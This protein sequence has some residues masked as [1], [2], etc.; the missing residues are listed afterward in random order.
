MAWWDEAKARYRP[1]GP[2]GQVSPTDE[3]I[4]A[5]LDDP[6]VSDET[7]RELI[8]AW[9]YDYATGYIWGDVIT[10]E[11]TGYDQDAVP[12]E[13]KEYIEEYDAQE[14]V[15]NYAANAINNGALSQAVNDAATIAT[16]GEENPGGP[17]A[18][19]GSGNPGADMQAA[20]DQAENERR[21]AD[22][23]EEQREDAR[24]LQSYADNLKA[25]GSSGAANSEEIFDSGEIGLDFFKLFWGKYCR[26]SS[27]GSRV[28]ARGS[29]NGGTSLTGNPF[30]DKWIF[31]ARYN[32]QREVGFRRIGLQADLYAQAVGRLQR[33]V[34]ELVTAQGGLFAEWEGEAADAAS[35]RYDDAV[36]QARALTKEL[37]DAG[38]VLNEVRG[39]LEQMCVIKAQTVN[40]LF[41]ATINGIAPDIVDRL[42]TVAKG[43]ASDED[44]LYVAS[45][46]GIPADQECLNISD[47]V[48]AEVQRS[49]AEWCDGN[50]VPVVETKVEAFWD[51]CDATDEG[52]EEI[53]GVMR[54]MLEQGAQASSGGRR[55]V[56]PR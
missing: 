47:D 45:Q 9:S 42:V 24:R 21:Y 11:R 5:I 29:G 23:L 50:L 41:S 55:E 22:D 37:E 25:A 10:Q 32:E 40:G 12:D 1:A 14:Y 46:F 27:G 49:A 13:V 36:G 33:H 48:K 16:Y 54:E 26:Y 19:P 3:E 6:E 20:I 53:L 43:G 7:K 4:K 8:A 2:N 56:M 44:I 15:D 17:G 31:K 34:D 38:K 18:L 39:A 35:S 28:G 30:A 52:F 51:V